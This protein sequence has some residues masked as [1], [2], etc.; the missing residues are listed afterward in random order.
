MRSRPMPSSKTHAQRMCRIRVG[1]GGGSHPALKR[2]SALHILFFGGSGPRFR[3]E[4]L[5]AGN[6]LWFGTVGPCEAIYTPAA[7]IVVEKTINMSDCLGVRA[8]LLTA[9][10]S[11]AP[12]KLQMYIDELRAV[13]R[14]S[15]ATL[16]AFEWYP[17][18]GLSGLEEIVATGS[19]TPVVPPPTEVIEGEGEV[20][21]EQAD[22]QQEK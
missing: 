10:D 18:T 16:Q 3:Q 15:N 21:K 5:D 1:R 8:V 4:F 13:G 7:M 9:A 12:E 11:R 22:E 20:A 2:M 14:S 6:S 17:K 19:E